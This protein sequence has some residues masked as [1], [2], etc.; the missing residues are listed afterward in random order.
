ME[1]LCLDVLHSDWHDWRGTGR[2]EDRLLKP[3]W[4]EQLVGH[5][6]LT[7]VDPPDAHAIAALQSLRSL[8]QH[9]VHTFL[10]QQTLSEQAIAG[11]NTYLD[12][13]PYKM[14]LLKEGECYQ[15]QQVPPT[16]DWD[17]VLGEVVLSF[18]KLLVRDP[19]C[20]KECENPHCRWI[21]Y[22]E[23]P[24]QTRRWCENPC[25][26]LMRV[27]RFRARQRERN[28]GIHPL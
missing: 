25:A 24:N 5:W 3:G 1:A 18:V 17:H 12:A 28:H 20:L 8:M 23:S 22:D 15:L 9:I 13:A 2:D 6:G 27:R 21:Y 4:V 10:Q 14:H 26:N 19:S 16:N 7:V 11:L